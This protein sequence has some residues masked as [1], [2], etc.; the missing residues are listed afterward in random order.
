[1]IIYT[2]PDCS[3]V[4]CFLLSS[5]EPSKVVEKD[6]V[7]PIFIDGEVDLSF[8]VDCPLWARR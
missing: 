2:L 1:M 5:E 6:I 7:I 3:P 4:I 8:Q